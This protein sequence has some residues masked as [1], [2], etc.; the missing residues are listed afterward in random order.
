[1]DNKDEMIGMRFGRLTVISRSDNYISPSGYSYIT[2]NCK[3][4]CGK[5]KIIRKKNLLK[6][7]TNS[8]GCLHNESIKNIGKR[9]RKHNIYD[10]SGEYGIGY[11]EDN[12]EFYFDLDDYDKI[13]KYYW[14]LSTG[15]VESESF[16]NKRVKFHRFIMNCN[17][18]NFDIDHINHKTNDNRK[19]N[20]RIVTRSQNQMNTKLRKDNT[21]SAKGVYYGNNKWVASIQV[22]KKRIYLGSF[23]KF[24]DAVRVRKEAENKYFGEFN[25]MGGKN[26]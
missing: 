18:S 16:G 21:S 2:Y 8:C 6:G 20:L 19:E 5:E 23:D 4:D 11:T 3:C 25:Y 13:K 24:E 26:E 15:Y 14:N 22:N 9:N 10:L 7:N 12:K 1:M 17:N